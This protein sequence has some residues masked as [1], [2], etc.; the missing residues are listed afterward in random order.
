MKTKPTH[1]PVIHIARL[2]DHLYDDEEKHYA[3]E[4]GHIFR[5]VKLV[6]EW[7]DTLHNGEHAA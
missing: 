2:V 4:R 6:S 3:G 7:L 1:V 5:S